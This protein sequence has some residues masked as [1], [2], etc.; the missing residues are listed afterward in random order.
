MTTKIVKP[1]EGDRSDHEA[2]LEVCDHPDLD[3]EQRVRMAKFAYAQLLKG[4][5]TID[6]LADATNLDRTRVEAVLDKI[7]GR[8]TKGAATLNGVRRGAV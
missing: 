2:L 4:A 8:V 5:V 3:D 7:D 1:S 6:D